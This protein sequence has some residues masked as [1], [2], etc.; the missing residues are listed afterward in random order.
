MSP[1]EIP[2]QVVRSL[3]NEAIEQFKLAGEIAHP[4]EGG[5]ARE[6]VVRRFLRRLIPPDFGIDTGFVV[7]SGGAISRQIDIVIYRTNYHPIFEVA[8]IKHF[9]I[10]SVVAVIENKARIE[11]RETLRQALENIL[12]VKRL[13]RTA[14]GQNYRV[15]GTIQGAI[16]DQDDFNCQV[17]GVI[18]A[19][20]SMQPETIIEEMSA[21]LSKNPDRRF[22][23]NLYV[24]VHNFMVTYLD[25]DQPPAFVTRPPEA[26]AL[27]A[28]ETKL[29]AEPP[30]AHLAREIA[31]MLRVT[32]VIDYKVHL[33]F[34][35]GGPYSNRTAVP[36]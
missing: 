22:W 18:V 20:R 23:P 7:D 9:M 5:R 26:V 1:A 28:S 15:E 11:D 14:A 6:E 24:D 34:P 16:V 33:Y 31:N 35:A 12:S 36:N 32:P 27:A 10:E 21:F 25:G 17:L 4:G 30:L 3:A 2:L 8:G 29:G 13:D 19:E